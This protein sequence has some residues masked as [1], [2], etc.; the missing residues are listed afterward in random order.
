MQLKK[1]IRR[2]SK[3]CLIARVKETLR[4]NPNDEAAL[5][6]LDEL[7][8]VNQPVDKFFPFANR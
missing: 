1:H 4:F 5:A 6:R 8:L 2:A 7:N 3:P